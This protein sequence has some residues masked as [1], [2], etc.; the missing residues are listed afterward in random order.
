MA[1]ERKDGSVISAKISADILDRMDD[2]SEKTGI[3]KTA[4]I[5]N[6]AREYLDREEEYLAKRS[7]KKSRSRDYER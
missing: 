1:R 3:T 7:R 5:E 6:A 2:F 4:I